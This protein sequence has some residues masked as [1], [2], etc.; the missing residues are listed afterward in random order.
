MYTPS[1]RILERY[2]DVLVNFALNGGNGIKSGEVVHLVCYE[3]AK[4]LFMELKRAI[5][6]AGGHIIPD[7]RPDSG[8]RFPFDRVFF[9]LAK[10]HQLSFFPKHYAKGLVKQIDHS[11]FVIS[12]VDMHELEGIPPKKIMERG[13]A[14][15]PYMDWRR[16]K[17][18]KG[19][20]TW[21]VGL[22]GTD[23]MAK[24]ARISEKEYWKQIIKGRLLPEKLYLTRLKNFQ[25]F[26]LLVHSP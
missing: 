1:Q 18:N 19:K 15:K 9:E 7:Y 3:A 13:L 20:F 10:P 5:Y 4:P 26:D 17:E 23:A 14:W 11:L 16:E 8:D 21:T 24:E 22:Y 2:A 6:K 12:E 25:L